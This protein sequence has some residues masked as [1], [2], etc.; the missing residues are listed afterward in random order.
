MPANGV[1][2]TPLSKGSVGDNAIGRRLAVDLENGR[3]GENGG[4]SP[5]MVVWVALRSGYE[6]LAF[7]GG[8]QPTCAVLANLYRASGDVMDETI[9]AR[10]KASA[11]GSTTS[12]KTDV[13]DMIQ[14]DM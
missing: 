7:R 11:T 4:R 1:E 9:L 6:D 10:R 13:Q 14:N 8:G 12:S 2:S 3:D 5:G